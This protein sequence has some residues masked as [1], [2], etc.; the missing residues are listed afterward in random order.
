MIKYLTGSF[1][2]RLSVDSL[3][4]VSSGEATDAKLTRSKKSLY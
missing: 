2:S 4:V 1:G 3:S